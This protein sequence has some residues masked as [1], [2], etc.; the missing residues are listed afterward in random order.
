MF[1]KEKQT[2]NAH[3]HETGNELFFSFLKKCVWRHGVHMLEHMGSNI[4]PNVLYIILHIIYKTFYIIYNIIIK[5][6]NL[7]YIILILPY[8]YSIT[9]CSK[10]L[11]IRIL[12]HTFLP[13]CSVIEE[14]CCF[15]FWAINILAEASIL[16]IRL[17]FSP[18][19]SLIFPKVINLDGILI[20]LL[21]TF[22]KP[23]YE[24]HG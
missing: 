1:K 4:F 7:L 6:N 14:G 11:F 23:S 3:H 19:K 21:S 15:Q 12:C 13:H 10:R 24:L 8:Y 16:M 5:Y 2:G 20:Y 22:L 17:Q 9:I 18:G